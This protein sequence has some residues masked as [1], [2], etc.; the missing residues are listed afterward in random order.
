[1][2]RNNSKETLFMLVV[3][4]E[5]NLP[6][7]TKPGYLVLDGPVKVKIKFVLKEWNTYYL[8]LLPGKYKAS[9]SGGNSNFKNIPTSELNIP[10]E[11][12]VLFQQRLAYINN[13]NEASVYFETVNEEDRQKAAVDLAEYIDFS[14]WTGRGFIGFGSI[15]P[16]LEKKNN[17]YQLSLK[18]VPSNAEIFL[19]DIYIGLTP[20]TIDIDQSKHQLQF[21]LSSY[22]DDIRY[23]SLERSAE[24]TANLQ[25]S[26]S[27]NNLKN[28]A[29]Y[30][31]LVSPF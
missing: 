16:S 19:D 11:S 14:S 17:K 20:M 25:I 5:K 8:K 12:I 24:I 3:R 31:T 30:R 2:P 29:Y 27:S 7:G 15:K 9:F 6:D 4:M 23:I 22:E 1:M 28:K 10:E 21:R 26:Q 13:K 18:S